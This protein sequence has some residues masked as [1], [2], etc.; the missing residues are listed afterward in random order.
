MIIINYILYYL[1]IIPISLLPFWVLYRISDLLFLLQY[2]AIRYRKDVVLTNIKNSFP[3]KSNKEHKAIQRKFFRHFCDLVVESFKLFTISEEEIAKRVV[4][5]NPAPI[6]ELQKNKQSFLIALGHYNNWEMLAVAA[7]K[8][9]KHQPLVIYKPLT[10]KFFDDKM[11]L[12]RGKFGIKL[13]PMKSVGDYLEKKS[14]KPTMTCFVTDQSPSSPQ[15]AYWLN[16]LNQETGVMYGIEKYGKKYNLPILYGSLQKV[17]RGYYTIEVSTITEDPSSTA[18][19]AITTLATQALEKDIIAKPE[20][21]LWTHKRWK[22]NKPTD[23][24]VN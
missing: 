7:T 19:G 18:Y 2:Y 22:H 10:N 3:N 17:K 14:T 24:V 15:K 11:Q 12:T 8:L 21:W 1:V 6:K 5:V 20:Y 23:T 4:L 13:I 9:V 16:F